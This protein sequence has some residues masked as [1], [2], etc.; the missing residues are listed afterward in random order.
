VGGGGLKSKRSNKF[1][2]KLFQK[3]IQKGWG[4]I[5]PMP[6]FFVIK[7]IGFQGVAGPK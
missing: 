5:E 7:N 6:S 2:P 1:E 4:A 3:R